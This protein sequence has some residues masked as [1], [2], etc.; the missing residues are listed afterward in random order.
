MRYIV[1]VVLH[2]MRAGCV[3][4]VPF[5]ADTAERASLLADIL[6]TAAQRE[7]I[8]SFRTDNSNLR[9]QQVLEPT[10]IET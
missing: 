6:R 10:R 5:F 3:V 8:A 7:E 4:T 1:P 9:L 2:D